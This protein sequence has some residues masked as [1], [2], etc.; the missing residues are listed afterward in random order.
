VNYEFHLEDWLPRFPLQERYGHYS[1]S[2]ITSPCD[3]C[4]IE[5][6][7][8]G[9]VDQYDWARR[10]PVDVFVMS[11]GEP[12]N[13]FATK[14]G[15]LPYRPRDLPW[16][17]APSGRPLT[18]I[19]QF[20]FTNS[21]DIAGK[22]PGDL[23]LVFGDDSE[24]PIEPL[25]MEWQSLG[26]QDLIQSADMP[27]DRMT[28]APCFGNRCRMISYPDAV[29]T[30][31]SNYPQCHGKDVWSPYWIPQLQATQIGRAPYFIQEGDDSLPGRPLCTI[32]SVQPDMHQPYPWVNV[33][34]PLCPEGKWQYGGDELM[35]GDLG[36]IYIFIEEDGTLHSGE[37][38]Y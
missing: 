26:I 6:L 5:W 19:A 27:S 1:G 23:L 34:E 11:K 25:H 32:A 9:M 28:I 7:R 13:R 18:L 22:L 2:D 30:T 36:C 33:P 8:R 37:S 15:G 31:D 14:I 29:R 16:P 35:I 38:C 4:N 21:I 17:C 10:V 12:E 3:I 24:G 20:N